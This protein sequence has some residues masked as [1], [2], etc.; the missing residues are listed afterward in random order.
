MTYP[1]HNETPIINTAPRKLK[2][3]AD[4]EIYVDIE[5]TLI[6][7]LFNANFLNHNCDNIRDYIHKH[8]GH[9]YKVHI[10]TWGWVHRSEIELGLV[11]NLYKRLEVAKEHRGSI[12]VKEDAVNTLI[13]FYPDMPFDRN[14][15][16]NPGGFG[17][18]GFSKPSIWSLM[19]TSENKF[20]VLIDDT[21]D[22]EI[23]SDKIKY[24]NPARMKVV[25]RN[26]L[27][28]PALLYNPDGCI[29]GEIK[30]DTAF[31]DVR[32]QIGL[33]RLSGYYVMFEGNRINIDRYGNI[34]ECPEGFFDTI[35]SAAGDLMASDD[36]E[37]QS[38]Y[39]EK[40]ADIYPQPI[41]PEVT[42]DED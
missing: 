37:A 13:D 27:D 35:I 26:Y 22:C 6:D 8:D 29:I 25:I 42:D 39:N 38:L 3:E 23:D 31:E 14:T 9:H 33:Q 1:L 30:N 16:M 7:D 12:Y 34:E 19:I 36:K 5:G 18:Y 11:D 10:F 41:N 4:I 15:L 32:R 21:V 24:I 28:K 40:L 17:H 20:N 2:K